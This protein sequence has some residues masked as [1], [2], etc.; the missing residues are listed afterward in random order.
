MVYKLGKLPKKHDPRN[1]MLSNYLDLRALP[2]IPKVCDWTVKARD[3]GMMLN[4]RIGCCTVATGGHYIQVWTANDATQATVPDSAILSTYKAASGYDGTPQT[5][6]G[7]YVLDVLKEWRKNGIGG[8]KI[9]A[10][11]EID[12]KN[13]DMV[14][15]AVWLFGGVYYGI[16]LPLSYEGQKVWD[17]PWY[18]A[19]WRGRPGSAGGHAASCHAYDDGLTVITWAAPQKMTQRFATTYASEAYAVFSIA[20]WTGIDRIA[21]NS[22]DADA[23]MAD[24]QRVTK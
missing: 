16:E 9:D 23:L 14:R 7:A 5:D 10:F 11:A 8:H 12:P 13:P 18:G 20:D 3:F 24:L 2:P 22:F 19:R 1:L 21:P 17:V 15:A 6:R 4:D